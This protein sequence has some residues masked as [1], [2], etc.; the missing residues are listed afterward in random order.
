MTEYF[1]GKTRAASKAST[2]KATPATKPK[3]QLKARVSKAKTEEQPKARTSKAKTEKTKAKPT[4]LS[5]GKTLLKTLESLR[6][7]ADEFYGNEAGKDT[8]S[9][10]PEPRKRRTNRVVNEGKA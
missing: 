10:E 6:Q 5:Q 8:D 4:K 2:S 3:P 7:E 9:K 1:S